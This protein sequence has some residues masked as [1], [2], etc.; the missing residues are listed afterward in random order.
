MSFCA[1]KE[2]I[3]RNKRGRFAQENDLFEHFSFWVISGGRQVEK[4]D[5]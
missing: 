5:L 4:T 1:I 2:V 3:L